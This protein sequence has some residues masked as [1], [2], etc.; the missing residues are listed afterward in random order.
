MEYARDR[1][2]RTSRLVRCSLLACF[3]LGAAAVV[4]AAQPGTVPVAGWLERARVSPGDI[5][6]EAKLDTGA[7][8]ASIH[9]LNLRQFQRDGK[10]WVAFDVVGDDGRSVRLERPLVRVAQIKSAPGREEERPTVTL[11]ICIGNVFQI[12]EVSL[13][14][15][16][17]LSKPLLI[18]RRFL[19]GRLVVDLSH[20][21]LLEP[22][23]NQTA[24]P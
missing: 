20:R 18:G 5:L 15:R 9:A 8:T 11:G 4:R 21:Y 16:S 17:G 7:R 22:L 23:C 2:L 14:D 19:K 12:T 1:R 24:M 10:D 13:V 3:L 6:L